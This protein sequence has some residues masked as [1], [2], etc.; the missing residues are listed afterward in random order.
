VNIEI[1][2][3]KADR[4]AI[5]KVFKTPKS[6]QMFA[7]GKPE[8]IQA[9]FDKKIDGWILE[10]KKNEIFG[11]IAEKARGIGTKQGSTVGAENPFAL[12]KGENV[13]KTGEETLEESNARMS[14]TTQKYRNR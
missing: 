4:D 10:N 5:A 3:T 2:L 7:N 1:E 9:S 8:E 14:N 12:K 11:Q 6:F 13:L